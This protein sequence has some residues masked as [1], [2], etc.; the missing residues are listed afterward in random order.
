MTISFSDKSF[1]KNL[2]CLRFIGVESGGNF[3]NISVHSANCR[4]CIIRVLWTPRV[5]FDFPSEFLILL[6]R[7]LKILTR[8]AAI[9]FSHPLR[10]QREAVISR[11]CEKFSKLSMRK[12]QQWI[13]WTNCSLPW[14]FVTRCLQALLHSATSNKLVSKSVSKS[15]RRGIDSAYIH[16]TYLW[17][18]LR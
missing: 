18:N 16:I 3:S 13:V 2:S 9:A 8:N 17:V 12:R 1:K 10:T 6:K 15:L 7:Q 14:C 4:N 5:I 11:K